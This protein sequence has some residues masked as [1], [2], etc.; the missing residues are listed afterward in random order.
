M[1][2]RPRIVVA[3]D[4][5]LLLDALQKLLTDDFDVVATVSD[6]RTLVREATRLK[7]DI[8]VVDLAMPG[9][10]GLEAARMVLEHLA[11]RVEAENAPFQSRLPNR[12]REALASWALRSG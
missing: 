11:D 10:N 6:G 5:N 12:P 4:H 9:L 8:A 3:D 2:A 7:P 1:M